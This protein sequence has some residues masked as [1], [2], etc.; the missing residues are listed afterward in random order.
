MPG[1][2]STQHHLGSPLEE[3]NQLQVS[4]DQHHRKQQNNGAEI[5]ELHCLPRWHNPEGHYSYSADDRSAGAVNLEAGKFPDGKNDV[6][7]QENGV[8]RGQAGL[9]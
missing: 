3:A 1:P 8:T 9:G 5:N 7:G 6:A 4:D 2:H